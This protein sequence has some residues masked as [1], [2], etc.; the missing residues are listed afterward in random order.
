MEL[1][2]NEFCLLAKTVKVE[3]S[4][5]FPKVL[6]D[7]F[8]EAAKFMLLN[9]IEKT[10]SIE[11]MAPFASSVPFSTKQLLVREFSRFLVETCNKCPFPRSTRR[12]HK[13][14]DTIEQGVFRSLSD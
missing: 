10:L 12:K 3:D 1:T 8:S 13:Q 2:L 6:K 14:I 7:P 11:N 4:K 9:S 5:K